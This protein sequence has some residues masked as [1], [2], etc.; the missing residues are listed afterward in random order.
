MD[1][2][3]TGATTDR[4]LADQLILFA[5][6]AKGTSEFLIPRA[7]DHV[8]SNLWLVEKFLGTGTEAPEE[9]IL[10]WR[11]LGSL[12]NKERISPPAKGIESQG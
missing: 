10:P 4:H 3:R 7:T 12:Q 5:A 1:D 6:L 9:N 11:L 2:L 8:Q